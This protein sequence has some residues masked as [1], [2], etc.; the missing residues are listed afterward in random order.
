MD[1]TCSPSLSPFTLPLPLDRTYFTFLSFIFLKCILTDKWGFAIVFHTCLYHT[2]IRL[3]PSIIYSFSITLL[4]CYSTTFS[5]FHSY[6]LHT[7]MQRI[8]I[9]FA[10][11]LFS[12]TPLPVPSKQT[13]YYNHVLSLSLSINMYMN[14]YI[15][16]Y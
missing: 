9:L 15:C 4:P 2:L 12:L 10:I 3:T 7:Q 11:I 8:L 1:H 5:A 16:V 6:C 14:K 13:N